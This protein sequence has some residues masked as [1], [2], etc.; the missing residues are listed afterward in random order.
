MSLSLSLLFF[1]D[2]FFDLFLADLLLFFLLED[3]SSGGGRRFSP[4][5]VSIVFK[6]VLKKLETSGSLSS[7][8]CKMLRIA[9]R[10]FAAIGLVSLSSSSGIDISPPRN[11]T[12]NAASD[13]DDDD[14]NSDRISGSPVRDT[15]A[16]ARCC[17]RC[18]RNAPLDPRVVLVVLAVAWQV[19]TVVRMTAKKNAKRSVVVD[20]IIFS[21]F[22]YWNMRLMGVVFPFLRSTTANRKEK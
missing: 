4:V 9:F 22:K 3:F 16:R 14:D 18:T 19:H 11:R 10:N 12:N 1:F 13:S 8:I 17:W 20:T 6:Q 15:F 21:R 5:M 2:L 7:L